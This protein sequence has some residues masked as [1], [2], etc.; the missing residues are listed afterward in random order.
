MALLLD[1]DEPPSLRE[2]RDDGAEAGFD[3]RHRAVKQHERPSDAA[4]FRSTSQGH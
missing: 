3:G 2:M 1:G 4:G